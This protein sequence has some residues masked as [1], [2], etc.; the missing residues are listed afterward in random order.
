MVKIR[1]DHHLSDDGDIDIE[2]W[3]QHLSEQVKLTD[4]DTVRKA[5]ELSLEIEEDAV[6]EDRLW[7]KGHNSF[8][9]GLEMAQIL[10]EL[11]LDQ[12][13]LVAAILYRAVR[14]ERLSLDKVKKEFGEDVSKLID[15]VQQMAAISAI[16]TPYKGSVLGQNQGQLDNVRKMLITMIDDVR[17]VLIKLAERTCA[18]R[19]VKNAQ[20]EKRQRVAREVFDIYAPLAHRLGIGH[21]KWELE[22]LSFRYLH[23][24]AY[25]KIA[26]QLRERRVDRDDF[27]REVIETLEKEVAR[28]TGGSSGGSSG[29][30]TGIKT[31]ITG[32]S[33]HIYSIWRKM[34]RKN[35]D[36]SQIYDIRAFRMLVPEVRDCYA[37]LGIVHSLWRHI[38][39]E[40]DDYI[41]NPKGNG[42]RSLHTAVVGP[43]GKVM[44]IQIRTEEMHEEAELGVCAHWQSVVKLCARQLQS[45]L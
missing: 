16:H 36:F 35:L 39:N 2:R 34:R 30:S 6:R 19:A 38:P 10:A 7:A 43:Q 45:L 18:I 26:K 1:E 3:V 41:A 13:T 27:I 4:I 42:Y 33:K 17:V 9:T 8:Q 28:S 44:E 37:V 22:D 31:E 21:I 11:K 14:E 15:G 20:V 12:Q 5:C 40:F 32:R 29:S 25:K 23:D 24:T